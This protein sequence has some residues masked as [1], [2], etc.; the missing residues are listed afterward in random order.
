MVVTVLVVTT[1]LVVVPT[2]SDV[3]VL[4]VVPTVDVL[5]EVVPTVVDGPVLLVV[6][7]VRV[8]VVTPSGH[9]QSS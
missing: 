8:D 4:D 7:V 3:L 5:V 6:V 1:V 9:V 2:G